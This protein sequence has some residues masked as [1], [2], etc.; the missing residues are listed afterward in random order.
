MA[1][2]GQIKENESSIF[3]DMKEI[4]K[5]YIKNNINTE[6]ISVQKQKY[7]KINSSQLFRERDF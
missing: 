1:M 5:Q 7:K 4:V 3:D 2:I 6:S